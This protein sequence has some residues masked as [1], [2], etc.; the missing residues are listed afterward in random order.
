MLEVKV[1]HVPWVQLGK[2]IWQAEVLLELV[3]CNLILLEPLK[4]LDLP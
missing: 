3:E 4:V 2:E 1:E